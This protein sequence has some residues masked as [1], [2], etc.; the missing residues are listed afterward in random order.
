[1]DIKQFNFKLKMSY[2]SLIRKIRFFVNPS[3]IVRYSCLKTI[4]EYNKK[5]SALVKR[6]LIDIGCGSKPY[7][8]LFKNVNYVGIDF[9]NFS[10][11]KT[12]EEDK[13]DI[14]FNKNYENDFK[15]N[16]FQDDSFDVV[17]SF[18]PLLWMV[19]CYI[20]FFTT[21]IRK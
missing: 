4:K 16:Q 11:N 21:G 3:F 5:Y 18:Q 17:V 2:Y 15:L 8:N 9:K 1:M 20:T 12:Y 19:S 14:F 10:R 13:P 7:K 6:D